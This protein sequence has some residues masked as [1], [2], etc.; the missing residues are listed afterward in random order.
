MPSATS[1][2]FSALE[3]EPAAPGG[4]ECSICGEVKPVAA[5]S[6]KQWVAKAHS[7]KCSD[8]IESGAVAPAGKDAAAQEPTTVAPWYDEELEPEFEGSSMVFDPEY[9]HLLDMIDRGELH[10]DDV[11]P[12]GMNKD[13]TLLQ[14]AAARA[15]IPLMR[16]VLRRTN[17]QKYSVQRLLYWQ[18]TKGTNFQNVCQG[19]RA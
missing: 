3:A 5:Y 9:T 14:A 17:S 15:D 2:S 11:I 12:S 7:R 1:N 4:K 18:G 8:C 16:A 10:P 19:E 6:K 13:T